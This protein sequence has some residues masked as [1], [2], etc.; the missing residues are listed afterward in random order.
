MHPYIFSY[1]IYVYACIIVYNS[2][3]MRAIILITMIFMDHANSQYPHCVD[4]TCP[5][6]E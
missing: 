4:A 6:G 3:D 5:D 2:L 1:K